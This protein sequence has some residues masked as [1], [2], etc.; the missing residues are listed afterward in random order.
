MR[1]YNCGAEEAF[2][3]RRITFDD[4]IFGC[5]VSVH[6]VPADVCRHCGYKLIGADVLM[7]IERFVAKKIAESRETAC[8]VLP[9]VRLSRDNTLIPV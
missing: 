5:H 1:C 2:D 7:T 9:S 3:H 6:E 8:D 4:T